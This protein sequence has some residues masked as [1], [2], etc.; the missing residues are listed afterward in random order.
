MIEAGRQIYERRCRPCH[1]AEGRGDGPVA[2]DL[3]P[4]PR[5]F[6][7]AQFKLRSTPF[8]ALPTDEDLF[9]VIT[10]GLAGTAMEGWE[11][12][13]SVEER[14]QLVAYIKTFSNR[15]TQ[16][17]PTPISIGKPPRATSQAIARGA[18]LFKQMKCFLCHGDEG[19]G[20]GPITT[21][22]RLEWKF[23][24][25]ARNLTKAW[26][27]KGGHTLKDI[28]RTLSSGMNGTPMGSYTDHLTE[29]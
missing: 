17:T 16:E 13:L 21:T 24:Y 14:W 11:G 9:N 20:D 12:I 4:K 3:Y 6:T 19:R 22:L 2:A 18:E 29:E 28:Y 27:F 26:Q 7:T 8:G 10:N 1:G 15:F 5:D 25:D 23:P